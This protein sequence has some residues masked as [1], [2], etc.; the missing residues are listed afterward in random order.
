MF[1]LVDMEI[2]STPTLET[3]RNYDAILVWA[4]GS[5]NDTVGDTLAAYIDEGGGVVSAVF[6]LFTGWG[7]EGTRFNTDYLLL[8][9]GSYASGAI[10]TLGTVYDSNH[11]IMD[12]V[13]SITNPNEYRSNNATMTT[14]SEVIAEWSDGLPLVVVKE[15]LGPAN[16][17]RA[18]INIFPPS[19]TIRSDFWDASTDGDILLANALLWVSKKCDCADVVVNNDPGNCS[20]IVNY[21]TPTAEGAVVSQI[22]NSG[23]TSGDDFPVGSTIQ[24]Y[25]FD[26]GGGDLDTCSFYVIVNDIE[27]P[28]FTCPE[29]IVVFNDPGETCAVVNLPDLG[30][31]TSGEAAPGITLPNAPTN[32]AGVA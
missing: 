24:Q 8:N 29:D 7:I 4:D 10:T 19:S 9:L 13:T 23:L 2:Y 30:T 16:A 25:E 6:N 26:F 15:N 11:P 20:A 5:L 27:A 31:I 17:R 12:G 18:D 1:N 21:E 14:G 28:A 22:D 32:Q 3:L